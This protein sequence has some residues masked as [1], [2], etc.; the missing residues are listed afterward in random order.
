MRN[1]Y[2]YAAAYFRF[3]L[4]L[5]LLLL[6]SDY[7]ARRHAGSYPWAERIFFGGILSFFV[8]FF[9]ATLRNG[10]GKAG[11]DGVSGGAGE[12]NGMVDGVANR[13]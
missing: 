3:A 12:G 5:M 13:K 6:M 9:Y 4:P 11:G 8:A 10:S 2:K 1:S 7:M